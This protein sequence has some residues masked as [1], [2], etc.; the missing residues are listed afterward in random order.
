M[1]RSAADGSWVETGFVFTTDLGTSCEPRNALRAQKAAA[2]AAG[3]GDLGPGRVGPHTLR[4]SAASV[5]LTKRRPHNGVSD[6]LGHSGIEVTVDVYGQV[7]PHVSQDA[8]RALSQA[9]R[10]GSDSSTDASVD[11][12]RTLGWTVAVSPGRP[13][14]NTER[15]PIR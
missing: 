4:H 9:L 2:V 12:H 5:M 7:A 8:V 11:T 13:R 15:A 14:T 6:I 10:R 3:L 1:P